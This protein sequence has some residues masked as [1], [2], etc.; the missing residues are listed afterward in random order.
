MSSW[1]KWGLALGAVVVVLGGALWLVDA[2]S[3]SDTA[4]QAARVMSGSEESAGAEMA[5]PKGAAV[6]A[7]SLVPSSPE[8]LTAAVAD[9]DV[10]DSESGAQLVDS[11]ECTLTGTVVDSSGRAI[12]GAR[13]VFHSGDRPSFFSSREESEGGLAMNP[14]V[15]TDSRGMFELTVAITGEGDGRDED[16]PDFLRGNAQLA[17]VH[18]AFATLV[19]Q[20]PELEEGSIDLG[21]LTMQPGAQVSGRVVDESGRAI[22][23]AAVAGEHRDDEGGRGGQRMFRFLSGRVTEEYSQSVTGSD[24]R[25]LITGLPAGRTELSAEADGF[26]MGFQ[27]DL[28]LEPTGNLDVGD[29]VLLP[30]EM[31][32]G[33]VV[34]PEGNPVVE[35]SVNVSSMARIVVRRMEDMPRQQIGREMRMR[36]ET[37]ADGYF[38]MVG[39]GAGQYTV[40]VNAP[41]FARAST[42]NVSTGTR[43]L[44]VRLEPLGE[45]I[46][47]LRCASDGTPIQGAE[48][49]ASA[50]SRNRRWGGTN[51]DSLEVIESEEVPGEYSVF[52]AGP[53]GTQLVIAAPGYAT[54]E[55]EGVAVTNGGQERMQVRLVPESIIAGMVRDAAGKGIADAR[56]RI[57]EFVPPEQGGMSGNMEIRRNFSRNFGGGGDS[58]DLME[59]SRRTVTDDLG[60]FEIRGV[61]AGEWEITARADDFV[62]SESQILA[63]EEGQSQRDVTLLLAVGGAILGHVTL[64]DGTPLANVSVVV[65]PQRA[66]GTQGLEDEIASQVAAMFGGGGSGGTNRVRTE[67]DG[68]Y[69]VRSLSPGLYE[70]ELATQRGMSFGRAMA[71][72][73]EN[74]S[75]SNDEGDAQLAT[76][77]AGEEVVVN[78]VQSPMAALEGRVVAAGEPVEAVQVSLSTKNSFMPFGGPRAETDRYGR[79]L[80][81]NVEAGEYE[82]SAVVPGAAMEETI[83]VTLEEGQTA[84]ADLVFGG[85]TLAGRV[86]DAESGAGARDVTIVLSPVQEPGLLGQM[87]SQFSFEIVTEVRGGGGSGMSMDVGGGAQSKVKTDD[88]GE[89]LVRFLKPGEYSLETL[90]G[91][92]VNGEYG[93]ISVEEG[94]SVDDV[95]IEVQRGAT[96]MGVVTSGE[97]GQPLD[98]APVSLTS[99]GSRDMSMARNGRF[100]FEGLDAGDYTLE[101][102]GSG[103]GSDPV[104]SQVVTLAVG[105]VREVNLVTE[106]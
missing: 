98:G 14:E 34:D 6:E 2:G 83:S 26:Q 45:I 46:V 20:L 102:M 96:L 72:I 58:E 94:R 84:K 97:S 67:V 68:S 19:K 22:S 64:E 12:E 80:F 47:A 11:T 42:E 24:G 36:V 38:E 73:S 103:F 33:F 15:R 55:V 28:N 7:T 37:D 21:L 92:Y 8:S 35:A 74:P 87:Q 39:L 105:E 88:N 82:V 50:Q 78:I 10:V 3:G 62:E 40:H 30:G 5:L 106:G 13:I 99:N 56:V 85:A 81:E 48:L 29:L 100:T 69:E 104:V 49:V 44:S 18:G 27:E 89:F 79:Y 9:P 1:L 66:S 53:S 75:D 86:V 4:S 54:L 57:E 59:E 16:L 90:G 95:V 51:Q 76:V 32:A 52:G 91:A 60:Q 63:V 65:R 70:V 93:P 25:F 71:F 77:V 17:A 23:G 61:P 43:D 41:G 101:V 31:I